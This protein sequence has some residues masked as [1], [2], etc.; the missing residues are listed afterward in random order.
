M[1]VALGGGVS[2]VL[3]VGAH[4]LSMLLLPLWRGLSIVGSCISSCSMH[5][6]VFFS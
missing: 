4:L 3:T 6:M 2:F 5:M 1:L